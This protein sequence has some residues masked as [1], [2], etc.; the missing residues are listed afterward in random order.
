MSGTLQFNVPTK[1]DLL[2]ALA[3]AY[4]NGVIRGFGG[5][6]PPATQTDPG[7]A[8]LIEFT[9]DGLIFV[10]SSPNNGLNLATPVTNGE[11]FKDANTYEGVGLVAG[12]MT[13]FR[14][15]NNDLTRWIQ[16]SCNTAGAVMTVTTTQITVGGPVQI[17]GLRYWV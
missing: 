2:A 1:N 11:I 13:W 5:V 4:A 17:T 6:P 14:H 3:V 10:P 15:Y 9:K 12:L 8:K 16:G 7:T